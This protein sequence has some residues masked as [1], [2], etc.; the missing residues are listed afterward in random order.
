MDFWKSS[1]VSPTRLNENAFGIF[2][3]PTLI[4]M[5]LCDDG[6]HCGMSNLLIGSIHA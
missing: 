4:A 2:G 3:N 1:S 6:I 5:N